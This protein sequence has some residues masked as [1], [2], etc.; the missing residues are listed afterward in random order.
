MQAFYSAEIHEKGFV[1]NRLTE[2]NPH[3]C[4]TGG[5]L[6]ALRDV[7]VHNLRETIVKNAIDFPIGI[8]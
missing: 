1:L 6:F 7:E 3:G 4:V 5:F 2:S 8:G